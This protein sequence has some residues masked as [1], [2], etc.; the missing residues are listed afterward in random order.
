MH[1][2][3]PSIHRFAAIA[4]LSLAALAAAAAPAAALVAVLG[5]ARD[6][7]LYEST[8]GALSNG[9][10][11][12]FFAGR[13]AQATNSIRRG[14]VFFDIAAAVPAGASITGVSLKLSMTQA[15]S[16]TA[17]DVGLHRVLADWGEGTSNA[18]P[19][20]G[21]GAPA[22]AGDATWRH[23][24]FNTTL[25][26]TNGGQFTA[27]ASA[28]TP[29][30]DVADYTWSS[31]AMV[32]E[33]QA[34]LDTPASNYGWLVRGA[35]GAPGTAKKFDSREVVPSDTRPV[36]TVEYTIPVPAEPATWGRL[37]AGYR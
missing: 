1:S 29:V 5:A 7:T 26:S 8:T 21:A 31:P 23:R 13:T 16:T 10:G 2:W 24:F 37:K 30:G 12:S 20:G 17:V 9:A 33:V 35:E 6:N 27:A 19:T 36:L 25:W 15:S 22:T 14:L 11:P 34:W 32:A 4:A 28:T 18:G 3:G